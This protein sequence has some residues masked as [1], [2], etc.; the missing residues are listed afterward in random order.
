MP[1]EIVARFAGPGTMKKTVTLFKDSKGWRLYLPSSIRAKLGLP[2]FVDL[3][4]NGYKL[5]LKIPK[6]K[7]VYT[8]HLSNGSMRLPLVKLGIRMEE[9]MKRLDI[10]PEI[11]NGELIIDIG[12]YKSA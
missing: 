12:Q 11:K 8:R 1:W 9:G 5:M 3:Y 10:L 7:Q 2:E 4:V 6:K